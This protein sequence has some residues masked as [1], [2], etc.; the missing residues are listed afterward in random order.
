LDNAEEGSATWNDG[1]RIVEEDQAYV[2]GPGSLPPAE[3]MADAIQKSTDE[4][5]TYL[6]AFPTKVPL[7]PF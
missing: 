4:K 3:Q 6:Y 7:K 5:D 2:V 1:M